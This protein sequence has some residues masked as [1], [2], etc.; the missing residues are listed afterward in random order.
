MQ[1][2][3]KAVTFRGTDAA[4]FDRGQPVQALV[5]PAVI[6]GARDLL[7]G[8]VRASHGKVRRHGEGDRPGAVV[9]RDR[10][11]ERL[12][13][14][15]GLAGE[16]DASSPREIDVGVPM[17]PTAISS[18]N[19][20]S[21]PK[22]SPP[23]SGA[24][25]E[26]VN[27]AISAVRSIQ[28]GSSTQSGLMDSRAAQIAFAAPRPQIPCSSALMLMRS[29]CALRIAS[30]G[31]MPALRSSGEISTPSRAPAAKS[32]GQIFIDEM[33]ISSNSAASSSGRVMNAFR[34]S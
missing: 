12:R 5:V 22:V 21:L 3:A 32:N 18:R 13:Q 1:L 9:E 28:I 29:P 7:L 27:A 11:R 31:A 2:N 16:G 8:D 23:A 19:W 26:A 6:E 30:K 33:L 34:S 25:V 10:F 17:P 14:S 4:L 20:P 15:R 24:R